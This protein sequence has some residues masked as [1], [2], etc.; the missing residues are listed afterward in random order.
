MTDPFGTEAL[1]ASVLRAWAESPTRFTEDTNAE[2]DLR[3][4]AYRDRLLVEL[5]QNAA[6]AA[7]TAGAPGRIRVSVVD[8]E[9]RVANTGAPLTAAGVA[10]L[11]SLRASAKE[12]M[13]GRF[14]VGFAAVLA[15]TDEPRVLS[16]TGGVAFS[17]ARTREAAGRP[18]DV[19]VL[20]LPWP[21]DWP[22]PEGFDTEVRLP[23]RADVDPDELLAR[24]ADEVED[25]LLSLPWLARI[26]VG[27]SVWQRSEVDGHVEIAGP[28]GVVR[29]LVQEAP[30]G[31]W[32]MAPE[33]LETDV[34]HAPTPTDERLSLPARLIAQ[35]PLEP[36]R[37]R[38]MPGTDV[39]APASAYP[40]LVRKLPPGQR[41]SL[42]PSAGF[43]LSEVDGQLREAV[44]GALGEQP[45]LP[46]AGGD[47]PALGARVLGVDSPRL[48]E[49]LGE[50][51][52]R[53][54]SV[55]GP[56]AARVLATVGA[57]RLDLP[58]V[59][60]TLTGLERPPVWWRSLYDVLLPLLEAHSVSADDLGAL[61]VPLADD[62]TLPGPRGALLFDGE[63]LELLAEADIVGLRL[64]HPEAA[65]PLLERL[66]AKPAEAADL[67]ESPALREAVERSVEDAESGL[68]TAPLAEAVLR[69]VSEASAEDLGA[70]ALP[71]EDGWRRADELVLPTSPLLAVFDPDALGEDGPLAVLDKDFAARWP[72]SALTAVGVLDGF[73]VTEDGIRDLDLVADERWPEALRLIA[74]ER[75]TWQALRADASGI[76]RNA[77]LAGRAP[78]EWRLA[79]AAGL[80]GLY[81]P[82]PDV[83]VREDVLAAAGVR[84]GLE[85][86]DLDD[87]ADL[88]DRLGDPRRT[89]A[90]GLVARAHAALADAGLDW[91]ALDAPE[92]VRAV[93]GSVVAAEEAAVLD[94]PWLA[95]AWPAERLVTAAEGG[96]EPEPDEVF[97]SGRSRAE[98]LAELLDVP[99][100]SETVSARM[101]DDGEFV[102]WA[103]LTAIC[104]VAE[105]LD[106]PLPDGGVV[107]HEE[108]SVELDGVKRD[109]PWWVESGPFHGEH[110]AADTPAG[111]AR[112]FAHAAD[113]WADRH[114]IEAL[115]DDPDP[116]TL[117]S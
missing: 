45:W 70:L 102:P 32:A 67:L 103:E 15:V 66:G 105:L 40:A 41:L 52:P 115:L 35:V 8:G 19:P 3:V 33:P 13:V 74:G 60:E 44:I 1:R 82:V 62:R 108:L 72:G 30:G 78:Q 36:S 61:P 79:S 101:P 84:T 116:L 51:V 23:L 81:D 110:H 90:P 38:I 46:S 53:L 68:D 98:R 26:S 107:V 114:L 49:M 63:L 18:G 109:A 7:Q 59:V 100:L 29:W 71:A 39:T 80:A 34:L 55:C 87:A 16:R 2:R 6:D 56:E 54:V 58:E 17:E 75:E 37:R 27:D 91:A 117:F 106:M 64:V 20:R 76:A 65:H 50:L 14:G 83:G 24:L 31:L 43:P 94:R 47:I 11:A 112:A 10:S 21:D 97:A 48:V 89:V 9:L 95:A 92:R 5:A 93:D 85:V 12:G 57:E 88:L 104:L 28:A 77:V 73:V 69:L 99:L 111:L 22:V 42:V 113:R 4:G 96:P 25:L 86:A